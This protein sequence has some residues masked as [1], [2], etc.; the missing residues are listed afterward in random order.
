MKSG[1]C[2]SCGKKFVNA[3]VLCEHLKIHFPGMKFEPIKK[4]KS[5]VNAAKIKAKGEVNIFIFMLI[6]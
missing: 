1:T 2:F 3:K 6:I 4:I 5:K